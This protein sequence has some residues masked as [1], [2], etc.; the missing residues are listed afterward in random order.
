MWAG[1][2]PV[3]VMFEPVTVIFVPVGNRSA[4]VLDV[5]TGA[6]LSSISSSASQGADSSARTEVRC[7]GRVLRRRT[8]S[9]ITPVNSPLASGAGKTETMSSALS[10]KRLPGTA[11]FLLAEK[12]LGAIWLTICVAVI[13]YSPDFRGGLAHWI[14][15]RVFS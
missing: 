1:M 11:N 7:H 14:N 3:P 15:V 5:T 8:T 13:V 6:S 12:L 2:V 9:G 4:A 10:W